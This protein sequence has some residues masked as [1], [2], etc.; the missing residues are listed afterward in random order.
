MI[1]FLDFKLVFNDNMLLILKY[2]FLNIINVTI[3]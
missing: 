3:P 1:F 2:L